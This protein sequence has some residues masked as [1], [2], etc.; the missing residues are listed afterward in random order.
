MA[1]RR[2]N[3]E[4]ALY[5][6]ADGMWIGALT[7]PPDPTTG[8]RRRKTVSAKKK[9]DARRKLDE[10]RARL[11]E[12]G[13]LPTANLRTEAWAR[14]WLERLDVKPRTAESYRSNV[15]RF[16]LPTLG[17]VPLANMSVAHIR[18]MLDSITERGL[19]PTTA[20]QAHRVLRKMLA[21]AHA[22][23]LVATNVAMRVKAPRA[24]RTER[25]MLTLEQ[26][27]AVLAAEPDP[28]WRVRWA[29]ALFNGARQGEVLGIRPEAIDTTTGLVEL[30]WQV[31]RLQWLHG[32]GGQC[33]RKRGAECPARRVDVKAHE[34]AEQIRGG[35]WKI[36][37]KSST[38]WRRIMLMPEDREAVVELMEDRPGD[39][40]FNDDGRAV[41]PRVDY[42]RW[43]DALE[44]AGVPPVT[45]HSARNSAA[46][47]LWEAGVD[48]QMRM[49]ILGHSSAVMTRHYTRVDVAA[50]QRAM[51]MVAK[52]AGRSKVPQLEP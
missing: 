9:V 1:K 36:R 52:V 48:E 23:G 10:I 35:L 44:R 7:L 41:D 31:Q 6:R 47:L 17:K 33:G 29:I 37:P 13:D 42:G 28:M 25:S 11:K 21:D 3:D 16:I 32:C 24:A 40:L 4:G 46:T 49:M 5:Q 34:E 51:E 50:M 39:F 19:S 45:L 12:S 43:K 22:E 18:R 15:E 14:T 38:S 20:L 8:K 27:H 2:A 30:A 26:A